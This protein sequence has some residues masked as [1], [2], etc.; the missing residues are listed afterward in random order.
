MNKILP[1]LQG[2]HQNIVLLPWSVYNKDT[3]TTTKR[4]IAECSLSPSNDT[5]DSLK[6]KDE[7]A[8]GQT[9]EKV[10]RTSKGYSV[11]NIYFLVK[12]TPFITLLSSIYSL[13]FLSYFFININTIFDNR[14]NLIFNT[15]ISTGKFF[16]VIILSLTYSVV[17]CALVKKKTI[18]LSQL[19][20][21]FSNKKHI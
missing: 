5:T 18:N 21:C 17:S 16:I 4:K 2:L 7:C 1:K 14:N 13:S 11:E 20:L 10:A 3:N 15:F 6:M 12:F 19:S 8:I 9:P